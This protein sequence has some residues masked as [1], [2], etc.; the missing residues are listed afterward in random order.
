MK[1]FI[2]LFLILLNLVLFASNKVFYL[3]PNS[4]NTFKSIDIYKSTIDFEVDKFFVENDGVYDI[5]SI[6]GLSQF[7]FNEGY[8]S[9]PFIIKNIALPD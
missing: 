3:G 6:D 5:I 8:P 9:L 4:L 7:S 2:I 1:K